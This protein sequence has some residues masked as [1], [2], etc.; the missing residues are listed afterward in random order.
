MIALG[1]WCLDTNTASS[2]TLELLHLATAVDQARTERRSKIPSRRARH[3]GAST[4][5][6]HDGQAGRLV[7]DRVPLLL[8]DFWVSSIGSL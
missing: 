8:L 1:C 2:V 6:R 7:L 4:A 3:I 5:W